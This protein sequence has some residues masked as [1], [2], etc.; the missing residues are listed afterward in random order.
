MPTRLRFTSIGSA[1]P[2]A[3]Y[4]TVAMQS[5][6]ARPDRSELL[7]DSVEWCLDG[8]TARVVLARP[9]TGN[10]LNVAMANGL[11]EA[12]RRV[13]DGARDG[14]IRV[15]LLTAEGSAFCVGGD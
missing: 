6:S 5:Y 14:T 7:H 3:E 13:R 10:A 9:E 11:V 2:F 1:E 4:T 12:A 15:A 8:A